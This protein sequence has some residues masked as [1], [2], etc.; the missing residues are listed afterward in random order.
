MPIRI[1]HGDCLDVI[2]R[3]V[4]DGIAVDAVVTDPPYHLTQNSR[5]GSPRTNDPATPFGRTRLAD[6]GFMGRVWD[7]GDLAFRP[8]TWATIADVMKP[9]AHL[10]AFGGTRTYHRMACA[11]EDAGLELRDS[12]FWLYG[13]GFPKSHDFACDHEETRRLGFRAVKP[14]FVG[15]L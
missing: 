12:I 6:K 7:G 13:Q 3:L 9:G 11:I 10:V 8:E 5:R 15:L 1:E 2:P 4:R 14:G